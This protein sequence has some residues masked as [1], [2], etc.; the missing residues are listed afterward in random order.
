MEIGIGAPS[1]FNVSGINKR[2]EKL[3]RIHKIPNGIN[4]D[5]GTGKGAYYE[6]I[7]FYS[8]K[9]FA[10]D[11]EISFL[12]KFKEK[13]QPNSNRIFN[14]K[15]EQLPIKSEKFDAAFIIE[16][17]EHVDDVDMTI[18]EINRILKKDGFLYLT[19]P[20]KYFLL[21]THMVKFGKLS[22]K[23]KYVPFLTMI[24]FI[25]EIIGTA[26]RFSK[27]ELISIFEQ[28]NFSIVGYDYMMPPFDYFKYGRKYLKSIT[29]SMEH[30][31]LKHFSM[32]IVAVFKKNN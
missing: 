5:I 24:D 1:E 32:T 25:H 6:K 20:N 31:F 9:L 16:V 8:E 19:V 10:F 22:I 17:L 4:L 27:K 26:R 3:N 13:S 2:I 18:K 12:K 14:G 7:L 28:N 11:R 29:E 21:D 15:T 30:S 23:G